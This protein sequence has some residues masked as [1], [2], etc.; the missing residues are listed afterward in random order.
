MSP[1]GSLVTLIDCDG[2]LADFTGMYQEV[3]KERFGIEARASDGKNWDHFDYPEVRA[4]KNDIWKYLLSTPG[5]IRGLKKYSYTDE[6][7][8][9][10]RSIGK[11]ICVT[12][13]V[14]LE[15]YQ[16]EELIGEIQRDSYQGLSERESLSIIPFGGYYP[17]ERMSWLRNEAGFSR[18]ESM[19]VYEKF[20]VQ[21][22]I[23]IDDK[24][25]NVIQW[26]DR[27]YPQGSIP[28]LWNTQE[29]T[30]EIDDPRIFQTNSVDALFD[31]LKEK[32]KI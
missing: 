15:D 4:I 8:S 12:S 13:V 26:A 17:G 16:R 5:L 7:L 25:S 27:W 2:V 30:F 31:H 21:G 1:S 9:R 19:L 18:T 23:F 32:G 28:V 24:P 29:R 20:R 3:V 14:M 6:L 22:D 11:V 10:L